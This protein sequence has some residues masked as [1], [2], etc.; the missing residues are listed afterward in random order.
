MINSLNTTL[1]VWTGGSRMRGKLF[2]GSDLFD[3]NEKCEKGP[4]GGSDIW[5]F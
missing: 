3:G 4:R 5:S 1:N 2:L